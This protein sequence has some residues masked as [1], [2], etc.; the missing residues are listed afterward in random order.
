[1]SQFLNMAHCCEIVKWSS[2]YLLHIIFTFKYISL[3]HCMQTKLHC[4]E[5][6]YFTSQYI[7]APCTVCSCTSLSSHYLKRANSTHTYD[8]TSLHFLG[9]S[10]LLSLGWLSLPCSE[11]LWLFSTRYLMKL[12][13]PSVF[14]HRKQ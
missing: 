4:W 12:I 1:M 8:W 10:S 9:I 3:H 6:Y 13:L 5:C 11:K 2:I 7:C 14:Y